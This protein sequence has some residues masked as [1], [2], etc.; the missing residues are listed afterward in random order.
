MTHSKNPGS[1]A[2]ASGASE[3]DMLGGNRSENTQ[4][5]MAQQVRGARNGLR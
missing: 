1:A 5:S 2:G 4:P 3:S